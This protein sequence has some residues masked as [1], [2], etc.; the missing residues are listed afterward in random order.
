MPPTC[1]TRDGHDRVRQCQVSFIGRRVID[2][3][4][5]CASTADSFFEHFTDFWLAF[6]RYRLKPRLAQP[7]EIAVLFKLIAGE[8]HVLN[9]S[10]LIQNESNVSRSG[11]Q[12][13][14]GIRIQS[15]QKEFGLFEM[16]KNIF[17]SQ[18]ESSIH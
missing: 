6:N 10:I 17:F 9:N 14:S 5:F 3:P 13:R 2:M 1:L 11:N 15:C 16:P 7:I 12:R 4:P 8:S 18:L